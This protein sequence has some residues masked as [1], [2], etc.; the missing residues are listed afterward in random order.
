MQLF[1]NT[2]SIVQVQK[3]YFLDNLL[4]KEQHQLLTALGSFFLLF[5]IHN[6][7]KSLKLTTEV[8]KTSIER[9]MLKVIFMII[10]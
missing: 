7:M 1:L 4:N 9:E 6:G 5:L 8:M 10:T 2:V 3:L